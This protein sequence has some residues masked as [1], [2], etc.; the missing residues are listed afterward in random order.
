MANRFTA[1]DLGLIQLEACWPLPLKLT[2]VVNLHEG[3][4]A[5]GEARNVPEIPPQML[6]AGTDSTDDQ[7]DADVAI[8]ADSTRT[9]EAPTKLPHSS[10]LTLSLL[11]TGR[12]HA[13]ALLQR[14][15]KELIPAQ[16]AGHDLPLIT[17]Y[18]NLLQFLLEHDAHDIAYFY[19]HPSATAMCDVRY[20]ASMVLAAAGTCELR[21][22]SAIVRIAATQQGANPSKED[23]QLAEESRR[24]AY[25]FLCSAAFRFD[26]AQKFMLQVAS[27][28]N[29]TPHYPLHT[30]FY[31]AAL[32]SISLAQGQE[33]GFHRAQPYE[34][35]PESTSQSRSL[36]TD[37]LRASL[38]HQ[39][40]VLYSRAVDSLRQIPRPSIGK[41]EGSQLAATMVLLDA[42]DRHCRMRSALFMAVAH[43]LTA[44]ATLASDARVAVAHA[45]HALTQCDRSRSVEKTTSADGQAK[46]AAHPEMLCNADAC[47][48]AFAEGIAAAVQKMNEL[49]TRAN[50]STQEVSDAK[51]APPKELARAK[52]YSPG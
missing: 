46:I 49:V 21:V 51:L 16:W 24:V 39:C 38:A 29:A 34:F 10:K 4:L 35:L 25:K 1:N 7:W 28:P 36:P 40:S 44:R 8:E 18:V 33:I 5:A 41:G 42:L 12:A 23:V 26:E 13:V 30:H 47:I 3:R 43:A 45:C 22:A 19:W 32:S 11:T 48:V 20:D 50:P 2:D 37:N 9:I 15:S 27:L 52:P 17:R 6:R 14:C 31:F